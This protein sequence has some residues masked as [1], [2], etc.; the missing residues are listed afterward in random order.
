M[1]REPVNPDDPQLT[2]YALGE[3]SAAESAEFEARLEASP[4]ARKEL[5]GMS[6]VMSML[7]DGLKSEW[8]E[9][10]ARPKLQV[11]PSLESPAEET[12]GQVVSVDFRGPRRV[13]IAAAAA[14]A[15]TLVAGFAIVSKPGQVAVAD[16]G[17]SPGGETIPASVDPEA[18][19]VEPAVLAKSAGGV[20]VPELFLAEE[21][22]DVSQLDL[23]H[24]W[25]VDGESAIDATYLDGLTPVSL[26]SGDGSAIR[27]AAGES[28][29]VSTDRVDSYLPPVSAMDLR[30]EK[31][32]ARMRQF[33]SLRGASATEPGD[34]RRM[35]ALHSSVGSTGNGSE[36]DLPEADLR[37]LANF[38]T[39]QRELTEL[40]EAMPEESEERGELRSIL[41]RNRRALAELKRQFSR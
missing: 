28:R 9:E 35:V 29:K 19:E 30:Q 4:L 24:D 17:S 36:A 11:L 32:K 22:D 2:A 31:G 26:R 6:D 14:V 7:S 40:V 27:T 39:I 1:N 13:A 3:M 23:A 41:D 16:W 10:V 15:L 34:H 8:E 12:E 20:P 21:V 38:Q 37:L 25:G 18:G 33:A 5:E